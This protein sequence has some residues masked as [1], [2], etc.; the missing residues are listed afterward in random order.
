M[1]RNHYPALILA[2]LLAGCE[3]PTPEPGATSTT[4]GRAWLAG[5]HHVHSRYSVGWDLEQDPP[6]PIIGGDAIYP[7]PMNAL[8]GRMHGLDW[9]VATDHGGPLH[10]KVNLEQAWPEI[11]LSRRAV[12]EVL[13]FFGMELDSP[14]ADH[15]SIIMPH[16]DDEA[17][18]LHDLESR[19]D[20]LDR[21]P[22]EPDADQPALML[23]ALRYM[24]AM[25]RKP[26]VIVHHPSRSTS[27]RTDY[28]LYQPSELRD[29]NDTAPSVAVGM[30]GAPGHQAMSLNPDGS[31]GR[32]EARGAYGRLP[33]FG[34]FD[35]MT[36]EVGGLWDALL[37]EG[38][39]WW[40]T[41]N[42][43]AHQ[44][45]TEGGVDFWPGEYSKTW[46]YARPDYDDLLEGL[47]GGRVFVA[48]GDLVTGLFV[49]VSQG[50]VLA[51]IGGELAADPGPVR[52]TIRF[53]DPGS[54][55]H[56][57]DN[58]VVRRVDLITGEVTGTAADREADINTTT[59]VAAR[60]TENDWRRDGDWRVIETTMEAAGPMYLRVRG[61]NTDQLEP[62]PDEPGEDPW[63][64]LW[65]Y[66]NPVF[67]TPGGGD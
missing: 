15:S 13:Q 46:V 2:T 49:T 65:F 50:D 27:S 67:V 29:W 28:G 42:S 22:A 12:P 44:H 51:D 59:R 38:R 55:N 10:S 63:A 19:F 47:R 57:G 20:P 53:H 1:H 54:P 5:D 43:D 18:H 21:W 62:L 52:V 64:D 30:E 40:I 26:V 39:R 58:P 45:Y 61:T 48:L 3:A 66:A 41:A 23:E 34:G 35:V 37:G 24:D 56:H 9:M 33:T 32:P 31:P 11:R 4:T 7:I 25:P 36:A 60:F 17:L 8:M 14:G 6:A 16:G